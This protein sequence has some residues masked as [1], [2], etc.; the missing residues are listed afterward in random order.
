MYPQKLDSLGYVH[1]DMRSQLI[2]I[3]DMLSRFF[4]SYVVCLMGAL[5]WHSAV[6]MIYLF[7][8]N[9]S[10]GNERRVNTCDAIY[11]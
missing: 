6:D 8:R 4:F 7:S 11:Y 2:A 3:Y 5:R 9:C 1:E 10:G